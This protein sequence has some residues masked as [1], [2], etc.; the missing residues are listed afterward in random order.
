MD[1]EQKMTDFVTQLLSSHVTNTYPYHNIGHTLYVLE[2]SIAIAAH[3]QV[4][5][6][7]LLLLKAAALWHDTGYIHTM[8][9]HEE[10]SCNLAQQ[11]LP[12]FGFTAAEIEIISA[13]IMATK[14]PQ[15]THNLLEAILADA[16]LEYLSTT[17]ADAMANELYKEMLIEHP[18]LTFK[19]WDKIQVKFLEEHRYHTSY[20]F[21]NMEPAKLQYLQMIK[22]R[23]NEQS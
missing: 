12:A 20:C 19:D 1:I 6:K 7:D 8:L 17:D 5:G 2:K 15:I 21:A 16:D 13:M 23:N 18:L 22:D 11:H 10:E 9:H 4:S 3:L 14:L